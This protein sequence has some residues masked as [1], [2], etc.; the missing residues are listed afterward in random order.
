MPPNSDQATATWEP[1]LEAGSLERLASDMRV[2]ATPVRITVLARLSGGAS[3]IGE[4][5]ELPY[6]REVSRQSL[7]EGLKTLMDHGWVKRERLDD[8]H[9]WVYALASADVARGL[10]LIA[11]ALF[12]TDDTLRHTSRMLRELVPDSLAE[13]RRNPRFCRRCERLTG[14]YHHHRTNPGTARQAVV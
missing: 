5:S 14:W 10:R 13:S 2:I 12:D 1:L 9:P 6:V 7:H 4:L 3:E 8:R 11:L